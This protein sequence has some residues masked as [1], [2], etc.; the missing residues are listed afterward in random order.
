M[1]EVA[2]AL[3]NKVLIVTTL[4]VRLSYISSFCFAFLDGRGISQLY[5]SYSQR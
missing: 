5:T 2:G 4:L 3:K 1:H